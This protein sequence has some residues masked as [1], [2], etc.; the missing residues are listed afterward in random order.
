MVSIVGSKLHLASVRIKFS[1]FYR[2]P[3]DWKSS[4]QANI[5]LLNR[6]DII[7][8]AY[9]FKKHMAVLNDLQHFYSA[10]VE[11]HNTNIC[12]FS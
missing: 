6:H 5:E 8:L 12:H 7:N 10:L 11:V 3:V 9:V 1:T 4:G 2:Q